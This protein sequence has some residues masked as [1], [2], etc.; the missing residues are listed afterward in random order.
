MEVKKI[1][2]TDLSTGMKLTLSN[3]DI[4]SIRQSAD[5]DIFYIHTYNG[6]FT[7]S[8]LMWVKE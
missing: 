3:W 5:K 2:F 6:N 8:Y 1:T 7:A 4:K